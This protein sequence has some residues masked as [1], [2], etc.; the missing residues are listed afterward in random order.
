LDLSTSKEIYSLGA[1]VFYGTQPPKKNLNFKLFGTCNLGGMIET[2]IIQ[3]Y[4]NL[5]H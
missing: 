5:K 3:L 1:R 4:S 2:I